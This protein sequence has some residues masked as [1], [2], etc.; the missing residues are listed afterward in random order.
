MNCQKVVISLKRFLLIEQCPADW[1]NLDLY[2]FRDEAVVF[3][4]GQS[5]LA[6]ARV[7]EHLLSGF[8]GHSI[9]GR[10]VWCNWPKSMKF[11]I[12]LLSS[13]H[14]QFNIVGNDVNAAE[15][16]L[17]QQWSPCFNVSQNSQPTP[18]PHPYAPPNAKLRCS[19]SFNRLIHEAERA[20]KVEDNQLWMQEME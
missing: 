19:R 2:L 5:H 10:F 11:T 9:M 12:E 8:K 14:E 17:I 16:L 18:L 6:F 13:Q 7:W 3:Y 20:V 4:A 1:K 15:R